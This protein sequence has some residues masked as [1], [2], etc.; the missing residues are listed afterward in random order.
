MAVIHLHFRNLERPRH[1]HLIKIRKRK[2][3]ADILTLEFI[4]VFPLIFLS[5]DPIILIIETVNWEALP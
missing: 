2:L 1:I 4:G 5:K 3:V